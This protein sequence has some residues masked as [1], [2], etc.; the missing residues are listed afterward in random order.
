MPPADLQSPS[1][2]EQSGPSVPGETLTPMTGENLPAKAEDRTS[3]HKATRGRG[4]N[5][6]MYWFARGIL[7]PFFHIYFRMSRLGREHIPQE[8]GVIVAANHRSFLDP[9]VIGMMARRPMYYVAKKEL[10]GNRFVGW[11]LNSLGAFP[12]DRGAGDADAMATAREVLERGDI[13]LIFPEGTRIRKGGLADPK[14][15]VGRLALETGA[16]VVPVAIIGTED[17]RK[18]WRIRPRKVRTRAGAP[19]TFP[20][21]GAPSADLAGAVTDRVWPCVELQ[22]QWLGGEAAP[23]LPISTGAD[24]ERERRFVRGG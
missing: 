23:Q 22:W 11:I 13:L 12:V 15:G 19:L 8:G 5:P 7:Q 3:L 20:Q 17:V 16:P 6:L 21:V 1:T 10:F 24:A 18:G 9:F 4:V 14:R 2:S